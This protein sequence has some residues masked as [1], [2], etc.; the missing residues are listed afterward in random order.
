MIETMFKVTNILNAVDLN[1]SHLS[2][3]LPSFI[4]HRSVALENKAL[5]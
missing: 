2:G 5:F 1:G 3:F 4:L